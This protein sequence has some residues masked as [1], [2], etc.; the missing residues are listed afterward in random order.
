[1][2]EFT[3][4]TIPVVYVMIM[5]NKNPLSMEVIERHVEHLKLLEAQQEL[6]LCGPMLDY[7]GGMV[8]LRANSKEEADSLAK[9]D[10]FIAEGYKTYVL[11]SLEV[12]DRSNNYLL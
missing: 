10:P 4:Q 7:A 2:M 12:A 3:S 5:E 1:M 11:Y 6:V 9:R 8:I